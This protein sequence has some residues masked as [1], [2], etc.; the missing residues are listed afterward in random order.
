MSTPEDLCPEF[1][2][3]DTPW[4]MYLPHVPIWVLEVQQ[5]AGRP[6]SGSLVSS[7]FMPFPLGVFGH[8]NRLFHPA[9]ISIAVGLIRICFPESKAFIEAKQ[10]GKRTMTAG[11][12]WRETV[13]MLGKEWRMC[14]YCIILMTWVS[15]VYYLIPPSISLTLDSSTST[16]TRR[17]T[18]TPPS[19]SPPKSSRTPVPQGLRS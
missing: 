4:G 16:P 19:C 18:H 7:H 17:K 14:I 3:K 12:F 10:S 6:S 13:S 11:E 8:S 5:T 15:L 1:Y 9:G 2:N